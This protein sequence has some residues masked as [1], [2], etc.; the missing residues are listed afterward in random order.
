MVIS[1]LDG[2][3][4]SWK[5]RS[6]NNAGGI[7]VQK[8]FSMFVDDVFGTATLLYSVEASYEIDSSFFLYKCVK[9]SKRV[10]SVKYE[11]TR[12]KKTVITLK[13]C[14]IAKLICL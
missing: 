2:S 11:L 6:L 9:L 14:F 8:C 5:R 10:L 4:P 12:D 3:A 13:C 7:L 1:N